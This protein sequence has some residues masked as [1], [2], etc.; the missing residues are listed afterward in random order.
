MPAPAQIDRSDVLRASL[1]VADRGGIQAVTMQRVADQLGVS[2][3]GLYRHVDSKAD[4]LDGLVE[5]LLSEVRLPPDD[6]PWE[7]RLIAMGD[8]LRD[9]AHRHPAVFGLLLQRPAA[10]PGSQRVR[11]TVYAALDAAGLPAD[12][13]PQAER[14][15]STFV[16]GFC[17]S[18]VSGRFL[19]DQQHRDADFRRLQRSVLDALNRAVNP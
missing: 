19:G 4:L 10:T 5:H 15:I 16:I 14:L 9:T 17:V 2:P 3:M 11:D 13:I 8:S 6:L 18:E 12:Q 1:A 7:R